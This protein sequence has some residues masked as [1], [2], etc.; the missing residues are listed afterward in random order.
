MNDAYYSHSCV[1]DQELP[2]ILIMHK[3]HRYWQSSFTTVTDDGNI[4]LN[5]YEIGRVIY[6]GTNYVYVGE[7]E[8]WPGK[9]K[10]D[11]C[12]KFDSI[13]TTVTDNH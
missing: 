1:L 9:L 4:E 5:W 2:K 6:D 13:E 10:C 3:Y 12:L 11:L 7:M 8:I